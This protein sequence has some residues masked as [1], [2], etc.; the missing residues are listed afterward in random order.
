MATFEDVKRKIEINKEVGFGDVLDN[1]FTLFKKIWLKGFVVIIIIM[2]IAFLMNLLFT[3]IG[4]GADE[5]IFLFN[6][7]L[8]FY[9]VYSTQIL[10]GFPQT[11][12]MS[13]ITIGLLAGFYK[14]CKE[15]DVN[16][17]QIDHFFHYFKSEYFSKL[18]M[19]GIIYSA[20]ALVAQLMF[21]IP[22]IYAYVPLAYFSIVFSNNPD[23]S[24]MEI[25]KLSF[26]IGTKKWLVSFGLLFVCAIIGMLGIIG[27]G[28]GL[29]FTISIAYLP[30]YFIYKEV[31]GFDDLTEIDQ[32]GTSQMD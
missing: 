9:S 1:C 21:V 11:I 6:G 5:N 4:L 8:D 18:F 19:L 29:L 3:A 22:Y 24:E 31:V 26:N 23:L 25:V 13:T 20:I 2:A 28:I 15:E 32:I 30:V 27:C 10:Y 7:S 14:I 17:N 12:I 16:N